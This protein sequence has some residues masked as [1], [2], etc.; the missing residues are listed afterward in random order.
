MRKRPLTKIGGKSAKARTAK[1]RK[2]R[3]K[4][5]VRYG[6]FKGQRRR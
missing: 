3:K 4:A 1:M 2:V 5:R 6:A